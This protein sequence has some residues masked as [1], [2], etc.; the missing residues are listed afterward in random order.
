MRGVVDAAPGLYFCGLG[1]Q[2]A[3]ASMLIAGTNRDSEFV[4]KHL[5]ERMSS[6]AP[7]VSAA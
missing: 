7:A 3:A 4:A 2:Y 5:V 6:R 1:F